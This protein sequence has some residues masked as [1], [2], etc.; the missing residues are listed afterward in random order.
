MPT[1]IAALIKAEGDSHRKKK[2]TKVSKVTT[3][4]RQIQDLEAYLKKKKEEDGESQASSEDNSNNEGGPGC[5]TGMGGP[6]K[7]QEFG[8][9]VESDRS[10]KVVKY[11]SPMSVERIEPLKK[12]YLPAADCGTSKNKRHQE[13]SSSASVKHQRIIH[14]AGENDDHLK[15]KHA[16]SKG[17]DD[18]DSSASETMRTCESGMERSIKELLKNYEPASARHLP[19]WCRIC[20][21]RGED[22][23][24]LLNHRETEFHKAA[25]RI[26][27]KMSYC[28][29]CRKQFTSPVQ[30]QEH[31]RAKV[32]KERLERVRSANKR[33]IEFR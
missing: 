5:A 33:N 4:E 10:G 6:N 12:Q 27:M 26:E 15:S 25:A 28:Q 7:I 24:D 29:L 19:F 31:L 11:I 9:I 2:I 18:A 21:F 17:H 14:F 8:V 30:L 13:S 1:S 32:H 3:L 20:K 23:Q 22:T 16:S